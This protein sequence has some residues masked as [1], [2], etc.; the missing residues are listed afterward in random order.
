M[1]T[2]PVFSFQQKLSYTGTPLERGTWASQFAHS[3]I[4]GDDRYNKIPHPPANGTSMFFRD[5]ET[6]PLS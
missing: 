5:A 1:G 6:F 2:K 3:V 4:S